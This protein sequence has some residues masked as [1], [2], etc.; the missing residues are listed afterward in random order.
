MLKQSQKERLLMTQKMS[1]YQ[2]LLMKLLQ[3]PSVMLEQ[4][5]NEEL[6]SNPALVEVDDNSD[7]SDDNNVD[8]F[9]KDENVNNENLSENNNFENKKDFLDEYFSEYYEGDNTHKPAPN[10]RI[11]NEESE[12]VSYKE[13]L[14]V[15]KESYQENLLEQ[16]QL[17]LFENNDDKKIAEYL[18]GTI[19]EDG[20]ISRSS[21]DIADDMLLSSNIV[22]TKE[23]IDY[24]IKNIIQKLEP[25][26]TGARSLQ[27]CLLIQLQR[28]A[29]PSSEA[30]LAQIIL[31]DYF[32]DFT[33]KNL[34]KMK[35]NLL[36]YSEQEISSAVA[37]IINNLNP[38]P[39]ESIT[40]NDSNS[41]IIPDF[42]IS[43]NDRK[44]SLDLSIPQVK[45]P[46][47]R[48]SKRY[49]NMYEEI[50]QKSHIPKKERREAIDFVRQKVVSAQW[51]IDAL[52]QRENTLF[53]TMTAIMEKQKDFFF[54]GDEKKL[55]PM[56]LKDIADIINVDIST[57]SRVVR[58]KYVETPYGIFP[59]R[60]FFSE[61]MPTFDGDE[62]STHEIRKII[63]DAINE[64]DRNN[65]LTDI[66]LYQ[67]LKDN[68]YLISR[69]TIA[70]YR[71]QLGF[72]IAKM[73][74]E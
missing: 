38:K 34:D 63:F 9:N 11:Y 8:T 5:I 69:R 61:A 47:L 28:E 12:K 71:E 18:I 22:T 23:H 39:G 3:I 59:L 43:I 21:A 53:A 20:Y 10:N 35:K 24:L 26:G 7:F 56:I 27:E 70:K 31:Q 44:H 46:K 6:E 73:R 32:Y 33:K 42:I 49:A 2:I 54:S 52:N 65:P 36:D 15:S 51:F 13:T 41:F 62:V 55:K 57:V 58:Q 16:L 30:K 64:E 1:P 17:V 37:Y 25:I 4:R 45:L 67:M 29:N 40:S 72:P 68:G 66:Q 50:K 60:F 14:Y 19:D 74:K 48:L